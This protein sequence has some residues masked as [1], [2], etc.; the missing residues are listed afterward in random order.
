MC[1]A[2]LPAPTSISTASRARTD[3][4]N[5]PFQWLQLWR[6]ENMWQQSNHRDRSRSQ[7]IPDDDLADTALERHG[8]FHD[9]DDLC[10]PRTRGDEPALGK[11]NSA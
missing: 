6:Q 11:K 7:Q 9:T 5:S 3:G 10:V 1:A 4:G 8:F 2:S